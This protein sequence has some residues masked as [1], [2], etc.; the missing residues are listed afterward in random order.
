MTQEKTFDELF[1]SLKGKE[2]NPKSN[3]MKFFEDLEGGYGVKNGNIKL[4]YEGN[5]LHLCLD[6]QKVREAFEPIMNT[7]KRNTIPTMDNAREAW[8]KLQELG[9]E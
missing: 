5:I 1:P 8:K 6:K 4:F 9:L 2:A 7:I 3:P